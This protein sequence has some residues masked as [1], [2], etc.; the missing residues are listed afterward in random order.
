MRK[1][2]HYAEKL[3]IPQE[4]SK[5]F[6][7]RRENKK[8]TPKGSLREKSLFDFQFHC[9]AAQSLSFNSSEAKG[10][11]PSKSTSSW[12][13]ESLNCLPSFS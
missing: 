1:D 7:K 6:I 11:T 10:I 12:N 2:E 4:H 8:A 13:A 9:F 3:K 5:S